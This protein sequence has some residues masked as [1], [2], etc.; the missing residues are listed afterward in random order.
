MLSHAVSASPSIG[1][2]A[3]KL[4]HEFLLLCDAQPCECFG[5]LGT[6]NVCSCATL[7]ILERVGCFDELCETTIAGVIPLQGPGGIDVASRGPLT[8]D[9]WRTCSKVKGVCPLMVSSRHETS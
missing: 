6:R 1:G 9:L 8:V 5:M 7:R 4:S 2:S 3:R